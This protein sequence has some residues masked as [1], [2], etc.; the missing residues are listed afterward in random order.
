MRIKSLSD[1]TRNIFIFGNVW[2]ILLF[3]LRLILLLVAS[4]VLCFDLCG[5]YA[6]NSWQP[7]FHPALEECLLSLLPCGSQGCRGGNTDQVCPIS[8][9]DHSDWHRG[10]PMPQISQTRGTSRTSCYNCY[11]CGCCSHRTESVAPCGRLATMWADRRLTKPTE[12]AAEARKGTRLCEWL[13]LSKEA[14]DEPNVQGNNFK[15]L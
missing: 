14:L 7:R 9:F 5:P 10:K 3:S 1:L 8:A 13:C 12:T 11:R 15:G 6:P 4:S 2:S